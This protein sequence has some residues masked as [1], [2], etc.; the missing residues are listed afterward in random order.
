[1]N[2]EWIFPLAPD[3]GLKGL[4]FFDAGQV[5]AQP[6]TWNLGSIRKSVGFGFRWLSPLGPL[7][8]EW[9]HN[10]DPEPDEKTTVWDFSIGGV[11]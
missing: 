7:R 9:G 3:I 1:M 6:E 8:L 4:L 10:L 2:S 5:Y 11:F